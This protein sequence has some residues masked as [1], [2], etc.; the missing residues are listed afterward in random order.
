MPNNVRLKS[1]CLIMHTNHHE[2]SLHLSH[3]W[4][5]SKQDCF[6]CSMLSTPLAY[7]GITSWTKHVSSLPS[8]RTRLPWQ[9][10]RHHTLRIFQGSHNNTVAKKNKDWCTSSRYS[11]NAPLGGEGELM[12]CSCYALESVPR[13]LEVTSNGLALW[14]CQYHPICIASSWLGWVCYFNKGPNL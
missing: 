5:K 12:L 13:W 6:A 7:V 11:S 4:K 2:P 1:Q 14:W 10:P 9:P 8:F 3:S